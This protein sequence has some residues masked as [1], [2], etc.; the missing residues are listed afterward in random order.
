M[1]GR[2]GAAL[3]RGHERVV[4][5]TPPNDETEFR[6]VARGMTQVRKRADG[7]VEEHDA[8][9]RED[10]VEAC[11]LEGM[12]LRV[13]ADEAYRRA[14]PF[15]PGASRGDHRIREVDA[16]AAAL[17]AQDPRNGERRAARAAANIERLA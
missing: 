2:S 11:R 5:G 12:G 8:E 17:R 4:L 14:F 6:A 1:F 7:V 10:P 9:A 13:A 3:S 16:D 15:R